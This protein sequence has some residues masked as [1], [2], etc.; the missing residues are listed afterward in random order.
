M[1][2]C[3]F[4]LFKEDFMEGQSRLRHVYNGE[5]INLLLFP[6]E[7]S[8]PVEPP[9]PTND[10][11]QPE[12]PPLWTSSISLLDITAEWRGLLKRLGRRRRVLETILTA[13]RP[14][15]LIGHTLIIGFPPDRRFHQELL[16][17]PDYRTCV[18]EELSR[19]FQV[20]LA[21]ATSLHPESRGL[22]RH[23]GFGKTPA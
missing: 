6:E 21:V 14:I 17:M 1:R 10:R 11:P 7:I 8:T 15:R 13:G 23:G 5:V 3:S 22:R 4:I 9:P 2:R 19:T 18:E 12:Y 20:G 16:D